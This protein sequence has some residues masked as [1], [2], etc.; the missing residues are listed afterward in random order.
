MAIDIGFG[1]KIKRV[2]RK[3]VN[4]GSFKD[5]KIINTLIKKKGKKK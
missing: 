3:S 5:F 2:K 1:V 4:S